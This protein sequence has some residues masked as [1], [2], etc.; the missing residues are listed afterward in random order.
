M[1]GGV[2]SVEG[3]NMIGISL[4]TLIVVVTLLAVSAVCAL[5][6]FVLWRDRQREVHRRR[7]AIQ[8]RICGC[9]YAVPK[10]AK[11]VTTC[12]ACGTRNEPHGLSPI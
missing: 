5:W 7:I 1:G 3:E 2:V 12:P 10:R 6:F 8:C 9:A 11:G 4:S